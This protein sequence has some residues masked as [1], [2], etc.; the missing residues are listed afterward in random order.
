MCTYMIISL[1]RVYLIED[2]KW[3]QAYTFL[4]WEV[5]SSFNTADI[6]LSRQ[7]YTV[8]ISITW[9]SVFITIMLIFS[10]VVCSLCTYIG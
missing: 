2:N 9:K 1:F 7:Y 3:I 6:R 8:I 4:F 5:S 10:N